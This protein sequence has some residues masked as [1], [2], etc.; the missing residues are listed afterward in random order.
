M[1]KFLQKKSLFPCHI[2]KRFVLLFSEIDTCLLRRPTSACLPQRTKWTKAPLR[3][4][5]R[6]AFAPTSK[7][8]TLQKQNS[9][10]PVIY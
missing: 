2:G 10:I 6:T 7:I 9:L 8:S 4:S 5:H 1:R 3:L